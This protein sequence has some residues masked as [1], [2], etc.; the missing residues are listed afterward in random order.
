M[1]VGVDMCAYMYRLKCVLGTRVVYMCA[2]VWGV[3]VH[4]RGI[5]M[6]GVYVVCM[7]CM[8]V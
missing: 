4:A 5:R 7:L 3:L 1:C 2:H 6:G 8:L